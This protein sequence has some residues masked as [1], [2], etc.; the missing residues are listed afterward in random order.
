MDGRFRCIEWL[1]YCTFFIKAIMKNLIVKSYLLPILLIIIIGAYSCSSSNKVASNNTDITTAIDSNR[2]TFTVIQVQPQVGR[3]QIANGSYS[4]ICAPNKLNSYLPYF[5]RAFA[6]A[7][8]LNNTQSPL[9]FI[10]TNF[11]LNKQEVKAGRW[12]I[13]VTPTDQRQV[14]QMNFTFFTN[15]T[16]ALDV[17]MTNR[18]PI[19]F[20]GTVSSK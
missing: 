4:V 12:S 18:S 15:G 13:I 19:R 3:S 16:A 5:G 14:Q 6:G 20:T 9:N 8:V 10:S 1:A 7:D 2:W 11:T 17:T